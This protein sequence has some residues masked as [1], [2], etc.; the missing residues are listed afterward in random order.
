[1][2]RVVAVSTIR[3]A[4]RKPRMGDE[5]V[6]AESRIIVSGTVWAFDAS[7]ER[8]IPP[9]IVPHPPSGRRAF[10]VV[11]CARIATRVV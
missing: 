7:L 4:Q 3:I 9:A 2:S 5:G 11:R 10:R 8:G 1:M 6:L